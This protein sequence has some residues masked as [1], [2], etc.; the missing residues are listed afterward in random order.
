MSELYITVLSLPG[1]NPFWKAWLFAKLAL[2]F[3][4][5]KHLGDYTRPDILKWKKVGL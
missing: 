2:N 5:L 1:S 3:K 4:A